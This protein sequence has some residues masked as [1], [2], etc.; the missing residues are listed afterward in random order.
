VIEPDHKDYAAIMGVAPKGNSG[1]G[2]SGAPAP[3]A[4]PGYTPPAT[5]ARPA[6]SSVPGGKPAWAQ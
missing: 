2:Q 5:A 4:A 6:S 1:G 3:L